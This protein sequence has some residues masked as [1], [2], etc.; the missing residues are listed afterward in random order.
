MMNSNLAATDNTAQR[1]LG[2][3]DSSVG[4]EPLPLPKVED[5]GED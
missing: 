5:Y 1:A 3:I 2:Q 4:G